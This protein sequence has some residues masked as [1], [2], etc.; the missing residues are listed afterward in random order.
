LFSKLHSAHE[1][2]RSARE[3]HE[4][5]EEEA[6]MK[7]FDWA[8]GIRVVKML[9]VK[10]VHLRDLMKVSGKPVS[11]VLWAPPEQG[12]AIQSAAGENRVH[13]CISWLVFHARILELSVLKQNWVFRTSSSPSH[14]RTLEAR[15][16]SG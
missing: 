5:F 1:S 11:Q 6:W 15:R 9:K 12:P 8:A 14:S 13:P 4:D 2:F 7:P 16:S 3:H 10:T